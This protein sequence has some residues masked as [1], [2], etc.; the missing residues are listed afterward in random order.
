MWL[1]LPSTCFLSAPESADSISEYESPCQRLAQSCTWR[2]KHSRLQI[3][4][5]RWKTV[6]WMRRLSGLTLQSSTADRGVVSWMESLRASR[7]SRIASLESSA[8][9]TTNARS[10]LSSSGSSE[11]CAPPWSFSKTS[12]HLFSTSDQSE[13][14]YA[15]WALELRQEYSARAKSARRI[16]ASDSSLWPTAVANDDNK[17]PEAHMAMKRRMKGGPRNSITSLQVFTQDW[18]TP[19]AHDERERGN[20]MADHHHFAHDLANAALDWQTPATDSFRSRGGERGDEMGL[21]QQARLWSTP[22]TPTG[23]KDMHKAE[24]GSGGDDLETQS[25]LWATPMS[26]DWKD[27]ASNSSE[28]PTNAILSRQVLRTSING[29]ES[30]QSIPRS[31]QRLN[32]KFVSWL[33]GL[34]HGLISFEPWETESYLLQQRWLLSRLLGR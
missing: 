3:W 31:H 10:G 11:R 26:R 15:A 19:Q 21:D 28:V 13:S 12:L 33:M 14:D 9:T 5:R 25:Q 34:P 17:S 23:G 32:P 20:T 2:G 1:Y 7:A 29:G 30:S 16:D 18:P 22:K 24:R 8:A 27:G 6:A 4:S